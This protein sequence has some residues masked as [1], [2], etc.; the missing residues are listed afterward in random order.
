MQS[1]EHAKEAARARE[2]N[3][4]DKEA[5]K[6][7]RRQ[8]QLKMQVHSLRHQLR[9]MK[10]DNAGSTHPQEWEALREQ[11]QELTLQHGYGK[12]PLDG[13]IL[14]PRCNLLP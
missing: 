4:E 5:V 14:N 10:C 7:K 12:L 3:P 6:E 8:E 2:I 11:L 13:S 9:E 1:P